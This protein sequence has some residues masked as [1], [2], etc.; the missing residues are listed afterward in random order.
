MR[1]R[2]IDHRSL[3]FR[4]LPLFAIHEAFR[5][6]LDWVAYSLNLM[7]DFSRMTSSLS[8][9]LV[10]ERVPSAGLSGFFKAA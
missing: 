1:R 8:A 9:S 2:I 3:A 7:P 5:A 4:I 10:D 6:I